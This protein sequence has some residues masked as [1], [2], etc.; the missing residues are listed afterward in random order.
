MSLIV[1]ASG[2]CKSFGEHSVLAGVD[3][4]IEPGAIVGL[5]GTNGSGKSTLIKC[6]LG[7]QQVDAGH[8]RL[9]GE[10]A[11]DLSAGA[12]ARLG[13]VPQQVK[14]YPW[15]KAWQAAEYVGAFYEHWDRELVESLFDRWKLRR[16]A[17]VSTLSGGE[18]QKLG[19]I[20][21][22]GH[23][24]HL[25]ILDEPAAAMD[26]SARREF[27]RTLLEPVT[28][29]QT[30]LFSTHILSD[31]ESV[32]THVAFLQDGRID[33]IDRL[34]RTQDQSLEDTFLEFYDAAAV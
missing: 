17:G 27:T 16:D 5:V 11:W 10:D 6:L 4:S 13:Y 22:L 7:L 3:L 31:L 21:A 26:P 33:R 34:D 14:L 19:L 9:F 23:R 2:V 18:A 1:E 29:G 8:V 32:A 20:V 28:P 12:K 15:M 24:P 30:V 25:L